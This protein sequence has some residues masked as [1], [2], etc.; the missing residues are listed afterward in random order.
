M[1]HIYR[2]RVAEPGE[3]LVVHIENSE[4]GAKLFD[5]TMKMRKRT[6]RAGTLAGV[7]LRYPLM[8]LQ[9]VAGIHYQALRLWIKRVP[10]HPHPR[11]M[12]T[13]ESES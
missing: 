9:V 6:V 4:S 8:T 5:A 7:L 1:E 11:T 3:S 12:R 10:F 2:W 13:E